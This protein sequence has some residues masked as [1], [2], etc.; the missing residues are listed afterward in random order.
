M[1][2]YARL[3]TILGGLY[4][5]VEIDLAVDGSVYLE[6]E[7]LSAEAAQ[8]AIA[9]ARAAQKGWARR[10]LKE[11]IAIVQGF[12]AALLAMKDDMVP[13]IAWQMGRPVRYGGEFNPMKDRADYMA[14]IA[15][16]A[17]AISRW[18]TAA[19]SAVTSPANPLAS[20]W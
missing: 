15:E 7:S 20:C 16:S 4:E 5:Q 13:E 8:A 11:R 3:R 2:A 6:R 17:L 19:H 12:V 1:G 10:P 14:S 9:A 18:K